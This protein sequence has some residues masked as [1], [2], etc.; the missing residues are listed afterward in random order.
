MNDRVKTIAHKQNLS[1]I[2]ARFRGN[3]KVIEAC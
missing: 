1:T 3:L 2:E